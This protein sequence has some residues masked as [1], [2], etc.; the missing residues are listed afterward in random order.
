MSR[1]ELNIW[2]GTMLTCIVMVAAFLGW[3]C[4]SIYKFGG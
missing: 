4:Y 2:L 1:E 3:A